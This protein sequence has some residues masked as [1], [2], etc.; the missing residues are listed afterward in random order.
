MIMKRMLLLLQAPL[1]VMVAYLDILSLAAVL[2]QRAPRPVDP[3]FRFAVL[4]PAHNEELLLPRLLRSL[5]ALQ[6]P[7]DLFDVHVV[8]DNCSDHTAA[9][10]ANAGATVHERLSDEMARG[11][12]FALRWLLERL[13]CQK[14]GYDAYVVLDAD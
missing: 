7:P 14:P 8:A 3:R 12:G 10:A 4:I 2:W 6:Y 13:R 5:A 9:V 1:A 11:K